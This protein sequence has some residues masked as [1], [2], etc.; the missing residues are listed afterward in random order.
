MQDIGF[1]WF[2]LKN[3]YMYHVNESSKCNT[4][5]IALEIRDFSRVF[6]CTKKGLIQSSQP[7]QFRWD[8]S[9]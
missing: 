4:L 7:F 6:Q 1:N 2:S 8:Y 3:M 5:K 9:D